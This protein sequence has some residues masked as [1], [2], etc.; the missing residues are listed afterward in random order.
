M[1]KDESSK[2][3]SVFTIDSAIRSGE[4]GKTFAERAAKV[5]NLYV[6]EIANTGIP[7]R[8]FTFSDYLAGYTIM[9]ENNQLVLLCS[10]FGGGHARE[11]NIEKMQNK[12]VLTYKFDVGS[13]RSYELS[14]RYILGSGKATWQTLDDIK[15]QQVAP[16][17]G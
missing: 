14:G 15:P 7:Y 1:E 6:R 9:V 4:L 17:D 12:E 3:N 8:V 5:E 2:F 16:A 10:G 13:G 11:F